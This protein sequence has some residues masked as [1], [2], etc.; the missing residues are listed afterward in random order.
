VVELKR[1]LEETRVTADVVEFVTTGEG[2][3]ALEKGE[4]DAFTADQVVL[5]GLVLTSEDRTKFAVLPEL[6]SFEPFALA[7]R[8]NDA[9]FRLVADRTLAG[10][11]RSKAI[12]KIYDKWFGSFSSKPN[13]A[14]EVMVQL[15]ALPE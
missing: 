8:R 15:N 1:L 2:K 7:M 12:L 10:L 3:R 5:I 14:F 6:Y 9:N 4:I 11:Y 13:S